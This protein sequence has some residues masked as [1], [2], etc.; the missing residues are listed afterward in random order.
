MNQKII[1]CCVI[2]FAN[3]CKLRCFKPGAIVRSGKEVKMMT[4]QPPEEHFWNVSSNLNKRDGVER[5]K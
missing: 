2:V 5:F 1:A 3:M 4:F